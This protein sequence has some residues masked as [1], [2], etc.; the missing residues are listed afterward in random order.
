MSPESDWWNDDDDEGSAKSESI[1]ERIRRH[2]FL[3]PSLIAV[4]CIDFFY[5]QLSFNDYAFQPHSAHPALLSDG[6][7]NLAAGG[8]GGQGQQNGD[9]Q[10]SAKVQ[11][12]IIE[13]SNLFDAD[14][15]SNNDVPLL[16]DAKSPRS[17]RPGGKHGR[18][19]DFKA[20]LTLSHSHMTNH[21][22]GQEI[23]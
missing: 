1:M 17:Q 7:N 22:F 20:S 19:R 6:S 16:D 2:I 4:L 9:R 10:S 14:S 21:P 11:M 13:N 8:S 23:S 12:E 5:I 3:L 15:D 18:S